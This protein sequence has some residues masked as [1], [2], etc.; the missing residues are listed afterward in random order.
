[1]TSPTDEDELDARSYRNPRPRHDAGP[2]GTRIRRGLLE[3]GED[4]VRPPA[5]QAQA[6]ARLIAEHFDDAYVRDVALTVTARLVLEQPFKIP[7]VAAVVLFARDENTAVARDVVAQA[8]SQ[9]QE[10]VDGGK[11][12]DVKLTLRFL[13]CLGR[14]FAEDGLLPILNQLFERAVDLQTASTEDVLGI[15]LTKII[16][17]TL[18]YVLAFAGD[19]SVRAGAAA[20]LDKT[21]VVASTQHDLEALVDPFP[22]MWEDVERP[23]TC[24][25]I[26]SL[27]QRQ[28]Q[29]EASRGWPLKCIPRVYDASLQSARKGDEKGEAHGAP[30]GDVAAACE[31]PT[32]TIPANVNAGPTKFFPELFFSIF[33]DQ[34]VETVP[35]TT[36][37]ASTIMRD[38]VVDTINILDFNRDAVCKFLDRI[39]RFWATGTF[40]PKETKFDDICEMYDGPSTWKQEDVCIDAIFGQLFALPAPEHKLV[41]YHSL[42]TEIC[43]I[44]PPG[45]APTLGR[46]IRFLFRHIGVID[47]ELSHRYTDWFAHHL[48][49][50][51][52]RWKWA[53]WYVDALGCVGTGRLTCGQATRD[54]TAGHAPA[55]GVY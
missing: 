2:P 28:L 54:A 1:M 8:G 17:L 39:D 48:S 10:A 24:A 25:S 49:N 18:P 41:Y 9:L 19:A 20:L 14:L 46:A 4:V 37:F 55:K 3:L 12:R 36:H 47:L 16:L 32:I 43:K 31:F 27:L 44:S 38:A 51:E 52:F 50:F 7:H 40:V 35:P 29:D 13:A 22:T 26:I 33:A 21:D 23:M 45:I 30:N 6:V 42:I 34:D 5:D 11:W 53:E 15:E